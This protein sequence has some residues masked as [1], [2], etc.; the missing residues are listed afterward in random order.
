MIERVI[1]EA[2]TIARRVGELGSAIATDYEGKFPMLIGSLNSSVTF[3]ADLT[4]AANIPLEIDFVAV[5]RFRPT[6]SVRFEKDTSSAVEGRHVVL[7]EP[8]I[9]T[10]LTVQY[11]IRTL[12]G[13]APASIAVCTLLDRPHRRL[14]HIEVRYRGFEI[15]DTFLVGYGLDYHGRYRELPSLHAYNP[16]A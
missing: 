15:T 1:F 12:L 10:G 2:Q 7:V 8:V 5:S 4:R 16:A 14:A 11:V 3:M 9:D 13:R 6:E